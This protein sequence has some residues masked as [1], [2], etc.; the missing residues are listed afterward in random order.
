MWNSEF[1]AY[2]N[3]EQTVNLVS[4]DSKFNLGEADEEI[5][6]N[7][8]LTK[9]ILHQPN[10]LFNYSNIGYQSYF[11]D[12]EEVE[13]IDKLYF[14]TYRLGQVQK[15]IEES[16]IYWEK[17]KNPLEPYFKSIYDVYLKA[18]HQKHGM[19]SYGRM[20]GLLMAYENKK[21]L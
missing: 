5:N 10:Y 1:L 6:A 21:E 9:I 18:N 19:Q 4:I 15:N 14:D 11:I 20:L 2:K 7:N 8:F 16:Y 3:L 12:K 13:L 17:Y